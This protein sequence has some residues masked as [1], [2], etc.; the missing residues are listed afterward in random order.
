[1]LGYNRG[2]FLVPLA[3][4]AAV[5]LRKSDKISATVLASV[6]AVLL[7]LAPLLSLFRHGLLKLDEAADSA[8][9]EAV[10]AENI[11][12]V[13]YIQMYG[14]APQYLGYL[15]EATR[16]GASPRWGGVM[17]SSVLSPVPVLGKAVPSGSGTAIYNRLIYGTS[18][19]QDQ[20]V[21]FQGELLMDFHLAGVLAGYVLLGWVIHRL[22]GQFE[23]SASSLDRYIWQYTAVWASFL[24]FGS[25]SVVSQILLYFFWPPAVPMRWRRFFPASR[26]T[27][28]C[29]F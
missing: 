20:V 9:L 5:V 13:D 7:V 14:S 2:A 16:W 18:E 10:A 25:V 28:P 17:V 24:I 27:F 22:Q 6:V 8:D 11:D 29:Q 15:L 21:P 19:I 3:A 4:M 1:M 26:L 23:W 12:P